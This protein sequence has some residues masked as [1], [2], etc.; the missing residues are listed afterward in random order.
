MRPPKLGLGE[1]LARPDGEDVPEPLALSVKAVGSIIACR[2]D[3][4]LLRDWG[5]G[6]GG[7]GGESELGADGAAPGGGG[8]GGAAGADAEL[9]DDGGGGG[10]GGAWVRI[11]G[12]GL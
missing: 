7:A 11:A 9:L 10:G 6:G 4:A 12:A 5:G 1:W 8:G 2:S 3:D